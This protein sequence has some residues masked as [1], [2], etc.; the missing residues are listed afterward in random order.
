MDVQLSGEARVLF[1]ITVVVMGGPTLG[2]LP[3]YLWWVARTQYPRAIGHESV[4]TRDG[5]VHRFSE[6]RAVTPTPVQGGYWIDFQDR[7]RIT[8]SPR[9]LENIDGIYAY[10]STVTQRPFAR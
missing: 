5:K 8:L 3:L 10:L 7:S 9:L 4:S 2:L 1:W 6:I